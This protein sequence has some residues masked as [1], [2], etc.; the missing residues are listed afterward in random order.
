MDL[1]GGA[2]TAPA[3]PGTAAAAAS[4]MSPY[5]LPLTILLSLLPALFG[6]RGRA[7]MKRAIAY[8]KPK[9][10]MYMS[11]NLPMMDQTTMNAI[12]NQLGRTQN[13]GWP[14]GG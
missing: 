14:G 12:L 9:Q 5:T 11:P 1:T 7:D 10:P 6:N 3:T 2:L 13:W 4:G 8:L